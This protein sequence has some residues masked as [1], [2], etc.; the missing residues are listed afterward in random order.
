MVVGY[1][2]SNRKTAP[3]FAYSLAG[4]GSGF[5]TRAMTQPLDVLKIRMQVSTHYGKASS[6]LKTFCGDMLNILTKIVYSSLGSSIFY[7]WLLFKAKIR[8]TA[9]IFYW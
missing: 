7:Q 3:W 4:A 5:V 8:R 2:P 1:D 9:N 6:K